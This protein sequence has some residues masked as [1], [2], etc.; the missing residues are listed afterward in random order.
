M[1]ER[2]TGAAACHSTGVLSA[3]RRS[4]PII[5][6]TDGRRRYNASMAERL[7]YKGDFPGS[8][9]V[10]CLGCDGRVVTARDPYVEDRRD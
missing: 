5:G 8:R 3:V 7:S 6:P 9:Q 10:P 1:T 4:T 2:M